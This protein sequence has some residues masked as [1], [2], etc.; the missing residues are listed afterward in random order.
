[1]APKPNIFVFSVGMEYSRNRIGHKAIEIFQGL[2]KSLVYIINRVTWK[3]SRLQTY[4]NFFDAL[5]EK[6]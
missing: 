1:M 4:R 6:R 3:R 5:Q 2:S